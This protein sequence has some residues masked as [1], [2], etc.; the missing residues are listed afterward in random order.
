MRAIEG[1]AMA[2]G[3]VDGAELMERAG[4]AVAAAVLKTWGMDRRRAIVLCGPGNNGGDGYVIA[5]SLAQSGW[6]VVVKALAAP[7]TA[8][9][10]QARGKWVGPVEPFAL[11]PA[12]LDGA[13][14]II[15]A[16]F[17]T[18]LVRPLA[19][20]VWG[21]LDLAQQAG[22]PLVAVD[23]L[24]GL[25]ADSGR[26][27]SLSGYPERPA[28]LTVAFHRAKLGHVLAEGGRLSGRLVIADIGIEPWHQDFLRAEGEAVVDEAHPGAVLP[29]ETGHK[30]AH[31]HALI[32]SGGTGRCGAARLA[33]RAALRV[34]AGLVTLACPEAALTENAARLDAVMLRPIDDSASLRALLADRRLNALCLGPGLGTGAREVG[35]VAEVLAG[36]RPTVLDADALTILARDSHLFGMLHAGCVL[37]PHDGEFARLF[38][39]IAAAL[40]AEPDDERAAMSRVDAV[41]AAAAQAG[42]IVLLKGA[43][44]VIATPT[45][46][47]AVHAALRDRAAPWLATAGA[48]DVLAGLIVG[49]IARGAHGFG[50]A[51]GAAWLHVEAARAFGPGLI[52]EDLPEMIPRVF[53]TMGF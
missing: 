21:A 32:L 51:Q 25:C 49:L 11:D 9:A 14:V 35:L 44:T 45:G 31:G 46:L 24:S 50:A 22:C 36:G 38:P 39:K 13:P 28:D 33:A 23:I 53:R 43:D 16:L 2:S 12:E 30:Y 20:G 52:A 41:R 42:C 3:Q 27:R 10:K 18:G 47:C 6:N 15:D 48:G 19:P 34:G 26:V 5:R 4:A 8:D 17:G 29:K 40:A 7:A 37:T 1:A